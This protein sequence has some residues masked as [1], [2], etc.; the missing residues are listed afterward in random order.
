[1]DLFSFVKDCSQSLTRSI[2]QF[3][4]DAR[5]L[6]VAT[7]TVAVGIFVI[8]LV[9]GVGIAFTFSSM[10][11]LIDSAIGA[12]GVGVVTDDVQRAWWTVLACIALAY[13][14]TFAIRRLGG[15]SL[16]L[17]QRFVVLV[18]PV[19]LLVVAWPM[20]NESLSLVLMLFLA[21]LAFHRR[22]VVM[23]LSLL[24]V[25][26]TIFSIHDILIFTATRTMTV[27]AMFAVGGTGLYFGFSIAARPYLNKLLA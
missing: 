12:R 6:F 25:V 4:G 20:L 16:S 10:G 22:W 13:A 7:R 17:T 5:K 9:R 27:G 2:N 23:T 18:Q 21:R 24:M 15:L 1:M 14:S 26:I 11:N 19:S 8:A 3:T